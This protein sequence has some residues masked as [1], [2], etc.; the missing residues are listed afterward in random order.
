MENNEVDGEAFTVTVAVLVQPV[1]L[2]NVIT[3]VPAET[4]VTNPVLDI[5][6]TLVDADTHALEAAGA[7][8]ELS[9]VVKP[10]Q[11]LNVPFIVGG[12]HDCCVTVKIPV[13]VVPKAAGL[14]V[15]VEAVLP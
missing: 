1:L 14:K 6:A 10:P 9:C 7:S 5:V 12:V 4:P 11:V 2:V 13:P 15:A 3:L 8:G